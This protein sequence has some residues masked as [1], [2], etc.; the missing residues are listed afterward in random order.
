MDKEQY[1]ADSDWEEDDDALEIDWVGLLLKLQRGWKFI[2]LCCVL[3]AMLGVGVALMTPKKYTVS[4]VLAP[5]SQGKSG[6]S[7]LSGMA[8]M[9]GL[10]SAMTTSADALNVS[11]FP[12]I[13]NSTSFLMQLMDVEVTPYVSPKDLKKGVP[14]AVPTTLTK[15]ITKEDEEKSFIAKLKE[16]ILGGA[17]EDDA[18]DSLQV[19]KLS[20]VQWEMVKALR[21]TVSAEVDKKT[22]MITVGVTMEDPWVATT[23]ADT[24]CN[25]LQDY[26]I[27]YRTSKQQEDVDYYSQLAE[28]SKEKMIKAQTA[29]AL[30]VDYDR[31]VILQSVSSEK[32]RLQQESQ[33]ASQIYTQMA[34]QVE[35][36]KA[37][38]Q[39]VKPVFTVL[40]P[41][42]MPEF[43]SSTSRKVV[44]LA[45]MFVGFCL[46]A[47]WKMFGEDFYQGFRN[48]I[49]AKMDGENIENAQETNENSK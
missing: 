19:G 21:K 25:R 33:L 4:V 29:Y 3:F 23:L 7:A 49:K 28:E 11:L 12:D 14:E 9:L 13:C 18:S 16:T 34:Q 48:E 38:L 10:G 35:M 24:V 8:S 15:F 44:V 36:A 6:S 5:E 41:A 20:P 30:S 39:E 31:S 26:V 37:K 43:P 17:D 27:A 2:G 47:A 46:S 42:V 22:G 1:L 32:E 45:F 40:Q